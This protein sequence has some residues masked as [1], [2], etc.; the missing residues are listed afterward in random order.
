MVGGF[1]SVIATE[2]D[3][4]G[5]NE[6]ETLADEVLVA[7]VD[8]VSLGLV[9]PPEIDKVSEALDLELV[10]WVFEFEG[11][12]DSVGDHVS[13]GDGAE[14]D[15]DRA[16]FED[17]DDASEMDIVSESEPSAEV[18]GDAPERENVARVADA[19]IL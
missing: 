18:V 14:S 17:E 19:E 2:M 7:D 8:N 9:V 11:S 12:A 6:K 10:G 13:D 3:V 5:V 1:V 16:D 4:E 15:G